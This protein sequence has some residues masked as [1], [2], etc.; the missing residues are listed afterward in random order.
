MAF[1]LTGLLFLYGIRYGCQYLSKRY[2]KYSTHLFFFGIMRNGI[3]IIF[4]TLIV[5]LMNI[6][7]STSPVSILKDI[8]AGFQA[9]AVSYA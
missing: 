4:A 7:K 6:G 1:G 8:P 2:P 9:M 5:F 3:L